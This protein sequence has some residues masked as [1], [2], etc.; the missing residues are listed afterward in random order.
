M[1]VG[2]CCWRIA[3]GGLPKGQRDM[4]P[5]STTPWQAMSPD[6]GRRGV[7][8]G[9]AQRRRELGDGRTFSDVVV[10]TT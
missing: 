1:A 6:A 8:G 3:A 10:R 7:E 5:Q 2:R 9:R 4:L